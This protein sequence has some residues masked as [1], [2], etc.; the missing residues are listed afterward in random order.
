[1]ASPDKVIPRVS[2]HQARI[3]QYLGLRTFDLPNH[4]DAQRMQFL[5]DTAQRE[6]CLKV[7]YAIAAAVA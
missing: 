1:M 3:Q 7:Q 2:E 4:P 5:A 6:Y